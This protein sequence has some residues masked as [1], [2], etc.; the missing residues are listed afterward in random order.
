MRNLHGLR[1]RVN[2]SSTGDAPFA[3][4]I[5]VVIVV[6]NGGKTLRRS[7]E[8]VLNQ[9]YVNTNLMIVDGGSTDGS[10]DIIE[11]Y[12]SRLAYFV[13]KKDD[14]IYD[15]MNHALE[16]CKADWCLFLG[17]DDVLIDSFHLV[18]ANLLDNKAVYYGNVIRRSVG[19]I[20]SGRFS[21]LKLTY[22]NICHQS[23]FYPKNC[24]VKKYDSEYK[25]LADYKYNIE[26]WGAG[27]KFKYLPYIISDYNNCGLASTGDELFSLN[28]VRV[29][30]KNL[31]YT[32]AVL[33]FLREVIASIYRRIKYA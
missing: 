6:L 16:N 7:I 33:W 11:G 5:S 12:K 13:S 9:T 26:L 25:L 30:R 24:F 20:Y 19:D 22:R 32:F 28:K 18:A 27:V 3:P 17:C 10:L 1:L 29:I 21:T 4:I 15:A 31:G 2:K 23:I 8:S 14:G